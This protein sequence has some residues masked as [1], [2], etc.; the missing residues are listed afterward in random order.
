[1]ITLLPVLCNFH[2]RESIFRSRASS[3]PSLSSRGINFFDPASVTLSV[4]IFF[5]PC[6]ITSADTNEIIPVAFP[7]GWDLYPHCTNA[8]S[9][10]FFFRLPS[11]T[12]SGSIRVSY[13][14]N[15]EGAPSSTLVTL[16]RF[17]F[18]S[19]SFSPRVVRRRLI[20]TYVC[21]ARIISAR[22]LEVD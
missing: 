15:T 21:Y 4:S 18:F 8:P 7:I 20:F 16:G 9:R 11:R 17:A 6:S 12:R 1:M 22:F 3:F 2:F 10:S 19:P 14:H 13:W 5:S